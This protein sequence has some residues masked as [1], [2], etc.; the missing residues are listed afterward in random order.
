[1]S[2]SHTCIS[3]RQFCAGACQAAS[4]VTLATLF[5]ACGGSPTSPSDPASPLGV[6]TGQFSASRV[7]VTVAGSALAGGGGAVLVR[8]PGGDK[9]VMQEMLARHIAL[10]GEQSGHVIFSD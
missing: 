1:M 8:C 7:Q 2:E 10:V 4:G 5:S 3:R 6:V 9:Y